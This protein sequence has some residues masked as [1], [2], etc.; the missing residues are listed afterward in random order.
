MTTEGL[1]SDTYNQYLLYLKDR[2][3]SCQMNTSY[4]TDYVKYRQNACRTKYGLYVHHD[5]E[6]TYINCGKEDYIRLYNIPW[7][8]QLP[9]N[10]TP[11]DIMEHLECHILIACEHPQPENGV[12]LGVGGVLE[13]C[14]TIFRMFATDALRY[15][16]EV[17]PRT[18]LRTHYT[19]NDLAVCLQYFFDHYTNKEHMEEFKR[20][21]VFSGEWQNCFSYQASFC[22]KYFPDLFSEIRRC[23]DGDLDE[24]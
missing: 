14:H 24:N 10:L 9:E 22:M 17:N 15:P 21:L 13:I 12:L 5:R 19:I 16:W 11:C 7:E 4:L 8:V 20:K 18:L 2:H 23:L 1:A 3:K 6:D